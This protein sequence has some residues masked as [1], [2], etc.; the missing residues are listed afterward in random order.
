M[1]VKSNFIITDKIYIILDKN[2]KILLGMIKTSKGIIIL[3]DKEIRLLKNQGNFAE[4]KSKEI[5]NLTVIEVPAEYAARL[6]K[7]FGKFTYES[8]PPKNFNPSSNSDHTNSLDVTDLL[9]EST[10]TPDL[11]KCVK[12][13]TK[14]HLFERQLTK[15]T[16]DRHVGANKKPN[17]LEYNIDPKKIKGDEVIIN[18]IHA[19]SQVLDTNA[20][21]YTK[22]EV[23]GINEIESNGRC[24]VV[25]QREIA[26]EYAISYEDETEVCRIRI[27]P[28]IKKRILSLNKTKLSTSS[29]SE[30]KLLPMDPNKET[31]LLAYIKKFGYPTFSKNTSDKI[32]VKQTKQKRETAK[33]FS[34]IDIENR[35]EKSEFSKCNRVGAYPTTLKYDSKSFIPPTEISPLSEWIKEGELGKI[36]PEWFKIFLTTGKIYDKTLKRV[37]SNLIAAGYA[38]DDIRTCNIQMSRIEEIIMSACDDQDMNNVNNIKIIESGLIHYSRVFYLKENISRI[39]NDYILPAASLMQDLENKVAKFYSDSTGKT[40]SVKYSKNYKQF[41]HFEKSSYILD[42]VS[43]A[44]RKFNK[45]NKI[46]NSISLYY[47]PRLMTFATFTFGHG[48]DTGIITSSTNSKII[49]D[50]Q[51]ISK[52]YYTTTLSIIDQMIKDFPG[53]IY[54]YYASSEIG[55]RYIY[56]SSYKEYIDAYPHCHCPIIINKDRAEEFLKI[57]N[58]RFDN[59]IKTLNKN[60]KIREH[61]GKYGFISLNHQYHIELTNDNSLASLINASHYAMDIDCIKQEKLLNSIGKFSIDAF[62][63]I[64]A[65]LGSIRTKRNGIF[66]QDME[67]I[68]KSSSEAYNNILNSVDSTDQINSIKELEE[69]K[70]ANEEN[71]MGKYAT[72]E[73]EAAITEKLEKIHQE[74]ITITEQFKKAP[75]PTTEKEAI[76]K[77]DREA[78][79]MNKLIL[80]YALTS[81]AAP[82]LVNKKNVNNIVNDAK[83]ISN[84]T[85]STMPKNPED[86]SIFY[87]YV[88]SDNQIKAIK[89]DSKKDTNDLYQFFYNNEKDG[90]IYDSLKKSEDF[91]EQELVIN[92]NNIIKDKQSRSLDVLTSLSLSSV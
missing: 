19:T 90:T 61:I 24:F 32:N 92:Y 56:N 85:R 46:A 66:L 25:P 76:E 86:A 48:S 16:K 44:D 70:K 39:Y 51:V 60:A 13:L 21:N 91:D 72:P 81:G 10:S 5:S 34:H 41:T 67:S 78:A 62:Y 50:S 49:N 37:H 71:I 31:E 42:V 84:E 26:Y 43:Q 65:H 88:D 74:F 3:N 68:N 20:K 87:P 63:M 80:E 30:V 73:D 83:R 75:R 15:E 27:N 77:A 29:N 18:T 47:E 7:N 54:G 40:V 57:F 69:F 6:P 1:R 4:F 35:I 45:F 59:Y 22:C 36:T 23:C 82:I 64:K 33:D 14:V 8:F 2:N 9:T 28:T 58:E 79:A 53:L 52:E 17:I 38:L 11:I 12:E 55:T 89:V